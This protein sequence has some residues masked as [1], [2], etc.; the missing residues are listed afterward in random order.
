MSDS[1]TGIST[2]DMMGMPGPMRRIIRI[3]LRK[4]ELTY[5]EIKEAC[6]QLPESKRPTVP[7][8]DEALEA[9]VEM[10]WLFRIEGDDEES[11]VYSVKMSKKEGSDLSRS[12]T[13]GK[14]HSSAVMK[15]LWEA[16]DEGAQ[17]AGDGEQAQSEMSTYQKEKTAEGTSDSLSDSKK[18]LDLMELE[19]PEKKTPTRDPMDRLDEAKARLD[20]STARMRKPG[21]AEK[22]AD[23]DSEGEMTIAARR[24]AIRRSAAKSTGGSQQEKE[25]G[26]IAAFFKR[27]FG[28]KDAK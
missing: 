2:I 19:I 3:M 18:K 15:N 20:A 10:E 5:A 23:G 26:P 17:A 7:E 6:A 22:P 12:G 14:R 8:I 11:V 4:T 21:A 27:L 24:S 28:G 9:L 1:S 25:P 16:V 13:R